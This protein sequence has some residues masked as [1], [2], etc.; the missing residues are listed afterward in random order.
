MKKPAISSTSL[1]KVVKQY[2]YEYE[3][4]SQSALYAVVFG[5]PFYIHV[6]A[7][8]TYIHT[9]SFINKVDRRNLDNK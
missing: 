1:L 5:W 9:Y 6:D 3:M 2:Y 4:A 8:H 7:S